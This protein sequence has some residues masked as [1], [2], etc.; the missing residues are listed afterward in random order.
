M[1]E[2]DQVL[3]SVDERPTV[4]AYIQAAR[5]V[6]LLHE[7]LCPVRLSLL[8]TFTIDPLVPYLEV[9]G[10]RKGFAADIYVGPFNAIR[11]E[12]LNRSSGCFSHKPDIVFVAQLLGDVCPPLANAYPALDAVQV[13]Q[14]V[15]EI[16]SDVVATLQTFREHSRAAVVVHNFAL[17]PYPLLGVYELMSQGSQT[18]AIRR[19]N[20][21]LVNAV[22]AVPGVYV[23]DFERLCADV[24]YRNWHDD[25]M[26]Y[27]GR[28]SLSA[29]ALPALARVQAAFV[30]AILGSPRKCLVLDLD[31]TLWGGVVGEDGIAGIKLGHTYPGNAFRHFQEVVLQLYHRGVL[32]AINSKN[33]QADVE[34][35]FK[36]HPDMALRLEH[37]AS[38]RINW[39]EKPENMVEIAEELNIGLDSLVFFDDSP[40]ER[41]LMRQALPHVLTLEVPSDPL[42]YPQVLLESSAFDRLSFTD[43][44]RRRGEM[45]RQQVARRQLEQSATSLQDFLASLLMAVSIHPVDQFVFPRVLDLIHKTNQFNLTSRRHSASQLEEMIADLTYGVFYLRVSDRFGDNGIVGVAIVKIRDTTAYIDTFLLS[46]RVIGRTVETAFLSFV[47]DWVRTGGVTEIEGEF[48]PTAK[49]APA[50]EFYAQHGFTQVTCDDGGSQWRLVL[51]NV[52]FQ[53][54]TYI[55]LASEMRAK[56]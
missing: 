46:C 24:G 5:E 16:I 4:A 52:P 45:Y 54:P 8:A 47:V 2:L 30:Q 11:Q 50:A 26:W 13:E 29:Q 21:H 33:N 40:V 19:L 27:L 36:S 48:I 56:A 55:Q 53:W 10:A 49:N 18:E 20:A 44:D 31:N 32:L 25:K 22:K 28:A 38:T 1:K 34:E 39:R 6:R 51:D 7:Q 3:Q 9:E 43:E 17:S 42:T 37:F 23:L 12:L 35:V 14:H 15:E 41:A